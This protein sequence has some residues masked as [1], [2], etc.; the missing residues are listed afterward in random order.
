MIQC[1]VIHVAY[2]PNKMTIVLMRGMRVI[3]TKAGPSETPRVPFIPSVKVRLPWLHGVWWVY[4]V[5]E[6]MARYIKKPKR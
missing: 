6:S 5:M 2:S 1:V 4:M 3:G